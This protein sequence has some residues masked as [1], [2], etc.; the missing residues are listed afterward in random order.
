MYRFDITSQMLTLW[1]LQMM[2]NGRGIYGIIGPPPSLHPD[3]LAVLDLML[4]L[5]VD[6]DM[7]IWHPDDLR[8]NTYPE[9]DH[10]LLHHVAARCHLMAT[11]RLLHAGA[12]V[13]ATLSDVR[14][15][16]KCVCTQT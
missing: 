11:R 12:D 16:L 5:G 1:A 2:V 10:F 8:Y 4:S 13:H 6:M 3:S 9:Y 7:M 15:W 14:I